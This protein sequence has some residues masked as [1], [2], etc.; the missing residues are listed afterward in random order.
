MN[1]VLITGCNYSRGFIRLEAAASPPTQADA[2]INAGR[3]VYY[4]EMKVAPKEMGE[5]KGFV[6]G[7]KLLLLRRRRRRWWG[8]LGLGEGATGACRP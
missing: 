4:L 3:K 1:V 2:V 8:H 5:A 7:R 6:G